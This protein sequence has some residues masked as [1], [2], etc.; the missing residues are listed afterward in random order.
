MTCLS[1]FT[2]RLGIGQG[3]IRPV[4]PQPPGGAHVFVIGDDETGWRGELAP[5]DHGQVVQQVDVTGVDLVRAALHLRV[6]ADLPTS[7]TWEASLAVDGVKRARAT[8][9]A[10]RERTLTDMAANVSKLSGVHEV[11]V[12]LELRSQ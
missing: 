2:A 7:L 1:V 4:A 11:G 9:P 3:R 5:G 12:R 10:G 8:C 6:P